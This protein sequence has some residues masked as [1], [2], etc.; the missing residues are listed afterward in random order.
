MKFIVD[1]IVN[2]RKLINKYFIFLIVMSFES[3]QLSIYLKKIIEVKM[4]HII[5]IKRI[6]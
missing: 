4:F 2:T 6:K 1:V 5:Y 3:T